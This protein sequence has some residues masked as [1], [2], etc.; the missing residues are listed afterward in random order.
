MILMVADNFYRGL[1]RTDI[2]MW[3]G[4]VKLFINCGLNYVLIFG[5]LGAPALGTAGAALGTIIANTLVGALML[6]IVFARSE[7]RNDYAL[8]ER[9]RFEPAVFHSLVRLSL[10]IG[11]QT[12][13]EMGG[14]SVFTAVVGRLGDAQLAATN[15][16]IQAWSVAFMMGFSLSVGATTLVGQCIGADLPDEARV[17]VRRVLRVGYVLMTVLGIVY[18]SVPERLMAVFV[19]G[20]QV[21]ELLPYARPLFTIVT[22]CLLLDL[23]YMVLWGALR[24]AGDTTYSMV[25]NIGSSW[26]LFVP[27]TLYAAPRWGLI[28]A[29]SCLV[30]HLSVMAIFLEIRFRGRAWLRAPAM[31]SSMSQSAVE[32]DSSVTVST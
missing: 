11:V 31:E 10:P 18:M 26:L 5:K 12:F 30:L 3:C 25:L 17:V 22:I 23:T 9:W 15:A 21:T 1:G 16:V 32:V 14:I 20:G 27:A 8:L 28:G 24:G 2:P 13:M 19:K 7:F 4:F 6:G 29:W